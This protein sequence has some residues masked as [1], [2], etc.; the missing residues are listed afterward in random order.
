MLCTMCV[1]YS[2]VLGM[3][4]SSDRRHPL[5]LALALMP[6]LPRHVLRRIMLPDAPPLRFR[7]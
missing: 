1:V 2:D 6:C 3:R 5:G 7:D 4:L